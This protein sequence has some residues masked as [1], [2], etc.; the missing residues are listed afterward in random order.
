MTEV[1][2]CNQHEENVQLVWTFA[3]PGA[4]YWCPFCGYTSGMMGAGEYRE[5]TF[6]ERREM[7][8]YRHIGDEYLSAR[9]AA[10]CSELKWEG[11]W[12]KPDDLPDH[13]KERIQKV[14]DEWKYPHEELEAEIE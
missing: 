6:A 13:E 4:E 7:V 1:R 10:C 12:I 8:K 2:C 14:I 3:F 9:S 11:K 5:L